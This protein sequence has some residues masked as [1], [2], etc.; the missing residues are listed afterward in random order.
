VLVVPPA[1]RTGRAK[2]LDNILITVLT[3]L[4]AELK[5]H[6]TPWALAPPVSVDGEALA[7]ARTPTVPGSQT[8]AYQ[9]LELHR[10]PDDPDG[11]SL[12]VVPGLGWNRRSFWAE[13]GDFLQQELESRLF[14]D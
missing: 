13:A 11:G 4:E 10:T 2:D 7:E 14:D 12:I 3:A 9:V 1:E 5:P 6:A 8:W